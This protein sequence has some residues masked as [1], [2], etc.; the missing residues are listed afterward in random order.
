M[1][2][3]WVTTIHG[4]RFWRYAYHPFPTHSVLR[5]VDMIKISLNTADSKEVCW[6]EESD[7][8]YSN[9]CI[10]ISSWEHCVVSDY[11]PSG[12]SS[13]SFILVDVGG[14]IRYQITRFLPFDKTIKRH[15]Q[16]WYVCPKMRIGRNHDAVW[17]P[18]LE[19]FSGL[20][21]QKHRLIMAAVLVLYIMMQF[22]FEIWSIISQVVSIAWRYWTCKS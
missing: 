16:I 5:E 9:G 3:D 20:N 13:S 17:L 18:T 19:R 12:C 7:E 15:D 14:K 21:Q 22:E 11:L 6:Y 8:K 10:N 2:T 1:I 4:P